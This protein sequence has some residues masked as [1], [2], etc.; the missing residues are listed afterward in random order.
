M[1]MAELQSLFSELVRLQIE[2]WN[3]VDAR[4]RTDLDLPLSSFEPMQVVARRGACRV[5][6]IANEMA[7]TVGGT[8]KLVDRLESAGHCRRRSNPD[9]RR[10]SLVELT[11]AGR[12]L[13]AKAG[14]VVDDELEM[15]IGSVLSARSRQQFLGALNTLR[16]AGHRLNSTNRTGV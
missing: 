8:S 14:D 10:S 4:L 2:L 5:Q 16:S 1:G 13:L 6:D 11:A 3:A 12:H 7:I 9:D 15:R